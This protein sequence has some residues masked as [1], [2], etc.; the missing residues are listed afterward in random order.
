MEAFAA[1]TNL[2]QSA[3]W[4]EWCASQRHARVSGV[5]KAALPLHA[6]RCRDSVAVRQLM[7]KRPAAAVAKRPAASELPVPKH[8]HKSTRRTPF[9]L[10]R[11]GGLVTGGVKRARWQGKRA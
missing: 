8:R 10:K 3:E 7:A 6:A 2:W 4:G 1:S 5:A 11:E 9:S